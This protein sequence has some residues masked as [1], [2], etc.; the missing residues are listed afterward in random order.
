MDVGNVAQATASL[1]AGA[2]ADGSAPA[3]GIDRSSDAWKA[4]REFEAL[5]L[6]QMFEFMFAGVRTDGMFGGGHAEKVYRSL[7]LQGY[8][9]SVAETG[10]TGIAERVYGDIVTYYGRAEDNR[11]G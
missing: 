4:A 2:G 1:R 9:D 10:A 3:R 6:S 11:D 5:V 8:A 7:L